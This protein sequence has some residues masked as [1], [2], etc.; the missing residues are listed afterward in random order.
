MLLLL[1]LLPLLIAVYLTM[2]QRRRHLAALFGRTSL[3]GTL[4]APPEPPG[5][6]S[7]RGLALRRHVPWA[8][9]LL[10]LATLIV[11][12]AR[13]QTVVGLPRIE[14]TVILAFDVSGSMAAEDLKPTRMEA[15]RAAARAF[16]VSQQSTVQIGI[17]SFSDAGFTTQPPTD[18][19][20]ALLAAINR[21]AVQSGTSLARGI[22]A[23]LNL[24]AAGTNPDLT[25]AINPGDAPTPTPVPN[26][27]YTSAAIVLLTDGENNLS[28]DPLELAQIAEDR[29]VRIHT[30]GIGSIEGAELNIDGFNIRSR[31]D[32]A[33]LK[34]ISELTGGTYYNA[35]SAEELSTI[36]ENLDPQLVIKPEKTE[37]TSLFA[38][39][40][41][42][43]LILGSALSLLWLSR[44]P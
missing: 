32:E 39:A 24:I 35:E 21:L 44:L 22:E 28:P 26:G 17:V 3:N 33:G 19:Q 30:V 29:G 14:G 13:P 42:I 12:M 1:M 25:L 4:G 36:Y 8:L 34:Q 2:Q 15:A 5:V 37:V 18:D 41:I 23:S 7:L 31:L 20:A 11:A 6:A 38:G 9:F 40:G 10:A 16:I 43:I 27:A